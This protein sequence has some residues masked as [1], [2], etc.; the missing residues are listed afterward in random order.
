MRPPTLL[1][2][3]LS[4][5]AAVG[6]LRP[7]AA[8][9]P[10]CRPPILRRSSSAYWRRLKRRCC[11]TGIESWHSS[12]PNWRAWQR[13]VSLEGVWLSNQ[14]QGELAGWVLCGMVPGKVSNVA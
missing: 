5:S 8:A 6:P 9:A 12:P 3:P 14:Q 7:A 10:P 13:R 2:L 4:P 1:L 11:S